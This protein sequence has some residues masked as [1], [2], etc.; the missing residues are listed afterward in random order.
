M[1][2][3]DELRMCVLGEEQC[4]AGVSKVVKAHSVGETGALKQR[5]ERTGEVAAAQR[6][7]YQRGEY[8]A[9]VLVKDIRSDHLVCL[10]LAVALEGF[11]DGRREAHAP[12]SSWR[13]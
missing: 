6:C 2:L 12:T 11:Y 9:P 5:L 3:L 1:K 10:S 4:G 7:D 8:E 13:F